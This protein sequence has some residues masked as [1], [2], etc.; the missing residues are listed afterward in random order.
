MALIPTMSTMWPQ[1][2]A[3]RTAMHLL[4]TSSRGATRRHARL[5]S[6]SCRLSLPRGELTYVVPCLTRRLPN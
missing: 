2:P 5:H 6:V 1:P 3:R 4:T